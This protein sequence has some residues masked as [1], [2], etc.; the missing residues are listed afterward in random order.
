MKNEYSIILNTFFDIFPVAYPVAY[1][2]KFYL[3]NRMV[4]NTDD[5]NVVVHMNGDAKQEQGQEQ[6][7]D[8]D[9]DQ[10]NKDHDK[11]NQDQNNNGQDQDQVQG[12]CI[13]PQ[14][15]QGS[16]QNMGTVPV[17]SVPQVLQVPNP[18]VPIPIQEPEQ[19]VEVNPEP[20]FRVREQGPCILLVD[21][22]ASTKSKF[23]TQTGDLTIFRKF[24]EVVKDLGHE[25]HR[26]LSWNSEDSNPKYVNGAYVLPFV[27]KSKSLDSTWVILEDS[28]KGQC[29]TCPHLGFNAVPKEWFK[30]YPTV[31]YITDGEI[32]WGGIE[33]HNLQDLKTKLAQS[34]REISKQ[35]VRFCI[36]TVESKSRDFNQVE[37]NAAGNDVYK[38]IA[39]QKLTG[40]VDQFV[41]YT[42]QGRFVQINKNKPDLPGYIPYED[43]SFSEFR[44]HEFMRFIRDELKQKPS[45]ED[46]VRIAMNLSATLSY[47]TKDKPPSVMKD[48]I[49]SFSNLFTIDQSMVRFLLNQGI[50]EERGGSAALYSSYRAQLKSLFQQ[51]DQELKKDVKNAVNIEEYFVSYPINGRIL[52][53]SS[54]LVDK[55]LTVCGAKYPMSGYM[56]VPVFPLDGTLTSLQEQCLRQWTRAV[57]AALYN[58]NIQSDEIIYL[59]MGVN[60]LVNLSPIPRNI[61]EVYQRLCGV[62]LNK[63]RLNTVDLTELQYLEAGNLPIPNSGRISDFFNYMDLVSSKLKIIAKPMKLWYEMCRAMGGKLFLAQEQHCLKHAE[64]SEDFKCDTPFLGY[65][66]IPDEIAYDYKCIVTLDDLSTT[67]G[68]LILPHKNVGN[69][70]CSPVYLLSEEGK[71]TLCRSANCLCPV[72]YTPLRKLNGFAQVGPKVPFELPESYCSQLFSDKQGHGQGQAQNK[73]PK[74]QKVQGQAQAQGQRSSGTQGTIVVL[75]GTVGAGK[76]TYAHAAKQHVEAKG[77]KCVI[78][79]TDFYCKQGRQMGDAV[80]M[81]EQSLRTFLSEDHKEKVAVIDVCNERY[82][83]GQTLFFNVDFAGWKQVIVF[84]NLQKVNGQFVNLDG[85]LAWSL[86]NVL[87]RQRPSVTDTH[88]LNPIDTSE[89]LCKDVHKKKSTALFGGKA[90]KLSG[91]TIANLKGQADAYA[92]TIQPFQF[93]F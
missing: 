13:E 19:E 65:D 66:Q 36:I 21:A 17:D 85:Y 70:V 89:Q 54:R 11:N 40:L 9:Q 31:Y 42:P 45:E 37:T 1:P 43:K 58:T 22:S 64:Y 33:P 67:G 88:W 18:Q 39:E 28:I 16:Q 73:H 86:R 23:S 68:Y 32:G 15:D 60:L 59:V 53:G 69:Y 90:W 84:P 30:G 74:D 72:C 7:H 82:V 6:D 4:V 52:S 71:T 77:G 87:Q 24:L 46:Q 14:Q 5:G 27:V 25:D 93:E 63:K 83:N 38:I 57:F 12:P 91:A 55:T 20:L 49:R 41:S 50:E 34:I 75:R 29:L 76:S 48:V 26:V 79:S 2:L 62:M 51:A 8:Q 56:S 61:K 35:H 92:G 3:L 47:L 80:R 78:A 10:N 44:T 81:V